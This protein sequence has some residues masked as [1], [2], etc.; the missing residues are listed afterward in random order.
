M[1]LAEWRTAERDVAAA[2][3]GSAEAETA[4]ATADQLREEYRRAYEAR[5]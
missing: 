1:I 3:P 5:R 4:R 2:R